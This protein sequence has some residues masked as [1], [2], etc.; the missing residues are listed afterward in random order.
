MLL[1]IES[2]VS[3]CSYHFNDKNQVVSK[4]V[5]GVLRE[6]TQKYDNTTRT[7]HFN[8]QSYEKL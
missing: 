1:E 3:F 6:L 7:R 5:P 2:T 8:L 4:V